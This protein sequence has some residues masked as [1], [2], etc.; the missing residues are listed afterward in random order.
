M[1]GTTIRPSSTYQVLSAILADAVRDHLIVGNPAVGV[2]LPRKTS[3]RPIYLT[4]ETHE[5]VSALAAAT[6]KHEALVLL[7][8][9]TCG[10]ARRP[11]C[12]S[13]TLTCCAGG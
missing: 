6:G 11:G 4:H 1:H 2:K 8:A 10:G 13:A 3:K 9:D 5:Q 7:L 12:G